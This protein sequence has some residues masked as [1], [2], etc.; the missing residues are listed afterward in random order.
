MTPAHANGEVV[1]AQQL[2]VGVTGHRIL[3]ETDKID[4]GI[5]AALDAIERAFPGR[6]LCLVSPLAEGADRLAAQRVLRR[7]DAR[8]LAPLPFP[9]HEYMRDFVGDDE[10]QTRRSQAQFVELLSRADRVLELPATTTRDEAYAQVGEYVLDNC[11]VLIAIWDGE[12]AQ[13]QGGTAEIVAAARRRKLPLAWVHAGNRK[14]GTSA[15]TSLGAEQ[16]ML[17]TENLAIPERPRLILHVGVTGHRH[18]D[19]PSDDPHAMQA[20]RTAVAQILQRL[21][22]T[23]AQIYAENRDSFR[24]D[25]P[26]L[27]L[28][29]RLADGSD[30]IVAL[31]ALKQGFELHCP[32][33]F[34]ADDYEKNDI[35][36]KWLDDYRRVLAANP[37][38]LVLD[39]DRKD[40]DESFFDSRRMVLRHS[41]VVI[42]IWDSERRARTVWGT[43][44][45]VREARHDDLL[46]V[47]IP[48]GS[49]SSMHLDLR[50]GHERYDDIKH[51]ELEA[52]VCALLEPPSAHVDQ[53]DTAHG[54]DAHRAVSERD[55]YMDFLPEPQPRRTLG[56]L[57]LVFR[58]LLHRRVLKLPACRV[59]PFVQQARAENA[60]LWPQDFP[61]AVA[62]RIDSTLFVPFAWADQ[63]ATYY[64]NLTR[65][66]IIANYVMAAA[67]VVFALTSY[68]LGWIDH[69][70]PLHGWEWLWISAELGLILAI[71]LNTVI[72]NGRRWHERWMDYRVLAEH[73]R[74]QR[75]LAP[76]G[77]VTPNTRRP[78]HLAFGDVRTSWLTWY[79]RALVRE[80]GM[81]DTPYDAAYLAAAR[82][83]MMMLLAGPNVGQICWHYD[84]AHKFTTVEHRLH[85][86]G[87][88]LF[89]ATGVACAAHLVW[90]APWLTL[91][92]AGAPAAGAACAAI[93][94]HLQL[95]R[96]AKH[97]YCMFECLGRLAQ[98]LQD[99]RLVSRR[100]APPC[101]AI[102]E[103]MT[104]EVLDWRTLFRGQVP[105]PS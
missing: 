8:L 4:A 58:N 20:I 42:A 45:L 56:G 10:D 9:R 91:I 81:L 99:Q 32:L 77:R 61:G 70:H 66:S 50:D 29:S 12:P 60:P 17:T 74:L 22:Q 23:V 80:L 40:L 57:W 11:D 6:P 83:A 87:L 49:P 41:D 1:L 19:L 88:F 69:L 28:F 24:P 104:S 67:A 71:V 30:L 72:A 48:P 3:T 73:L 52:R 62:A 63:L 46:V 100:L 2:R 90:H 105:I 94:V 35:D 5:D 101:E 38:I 51:E 75:V 7:N 14:P 26:L 37:K 76:L 98:A 86:I 92:A 93:A 65:T 82:T 15:A 47:H 34:P 33:P 13:G 96:V 68:A 89:G 18:D 43:T 31:E 53:P 54:G 95:D 44:Q 85:R 78:A 103:C 79:F 64:G 97:S 84:N 39:G 59:E 36:P 27:R 21:K 16:G 25:P 55:K 102:A